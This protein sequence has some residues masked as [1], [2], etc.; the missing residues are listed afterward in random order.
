MYY[1]FFRYYEPDAGRFVNQD[2]IGIIA[3]ENPYAFVPN[4]QRWMDISAAMAQVA[5]G[6]AIVAPF[7][8]PVGCAAE[9]TI[10]LVATAVLAVGVAISAA[11][12]M[13]NS[14]SPTT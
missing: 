8:D 11:V 6:C 3:S 12:A 7:D 2:P 13:S 14:T 4:I 10:A 5:A 9:S 1:N